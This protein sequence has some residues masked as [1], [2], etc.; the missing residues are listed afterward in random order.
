MEA[1]E[2]SVSGR[3]PG[4]YGVLEANIS[5]CFGEEEVLLSFKC[6]W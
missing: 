2:K 5:K 3:G 6:F 1:K 4:E